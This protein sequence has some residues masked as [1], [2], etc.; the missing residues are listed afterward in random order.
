[1]ERRMKYVS[2]KDTTV[3]LQSCDFKKVPS[4]KIFG[5]HF[6]SSH[7]QESKRWCN[8]YTGNEHV[9]FD[10]STGTTMSCARWKDEIISIRHNIEFYTA[11]TDMSCSPLPSEET[12]SDSSYSYHMSEVVLDGKPCYLVDILGPTDENKTMGI[13][14]IRYEINLWID[15]SDYLPVKYSVA[16]DLVQQQDTM[17]QYEECRLLVFE[18]EVDESRLTLAAVPAQVVLEDYVPYEPP[19]K[20]RRGTLAPD[21]SLPT[22]DGDTVRLA[23]LRGKVVLIDFFY[24]SCAPCCA[25]LPTLQ[26]LHE[27]YKDKG[28]VVVGIDPYDDPEKDEMADFLSKR[29]VTYTVLFSGRDLPEAY[30][31][32]EY[33]TLFFVNRKGKIMKVQY[34]FSKDMESPIEKQLLKLL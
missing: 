1:M 33:P 9:W 23:D 6:L 13:R 10:D 11:L 24:K 26:S 27:K 12:L 19:K 5:M 15:K 7:M 34:G 18:P 3:R 14:T 22:L 2:D 4:D 21:W 8:L 25:A 16:I 28:L 32:Y 17:Y 30:H 31:V 20:L 29:G